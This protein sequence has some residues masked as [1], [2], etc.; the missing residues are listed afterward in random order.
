M[1]NVRA[2]WQPADQSNS[3]Q[4][5]WALANFFLHLF[6]WGL[7]TTLLANFPL[8]LLANW[9]LEVW[10]IFWLLPITSFAVG[11]FLAVTPLWIA[12]HPDQPAPSNRPKETA[13]VPIWAYVGVTA[14]IV[15]LMLAVFGFLASDL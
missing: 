13:P 3:D 8:F 15:L 12:L 2:I 6:V 9:G 4:V 10:E 7:I 11:V 1:R 5:I 14:V